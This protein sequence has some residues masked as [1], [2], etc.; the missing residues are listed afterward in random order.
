MKREYKIIL[1]SIAIILAYCIGLWIPIEY[2][3]PTIKEE[4]IG[5]GEYYR[6]IISIIS[7][8]ITFTAVLV[9]LFKDDLR[10]YWKFARINFS[11]PDNHTIEITNDVSNG[12]SDE[13]LQAKK[14]ISRVEIQ[15]TGN[16]PLL[17]SEIYL[18]KLEYFPK[19]ST[20]PQFVECSGS[21]IKWNGSA[22]ETII[23]PPS[24]KKMV[25][26][27][28]IFAPEKIST[29]DSA[30]ENKPAKLIIGNLENKLG[31]NK[32]KW[33]ATYT[34]YAQNHKAKSFVITIEWNGLWK[35]RLT[36]MNNYF[37]IQKK[38]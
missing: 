33:H 27:V 28:E 19:D 34:V 37:K 14:Y 24:G 12:Q 1:I 6:L 36:E 16:L 22:V 25:T 15:N 17:N 7:A 10:E 26:I 5:K 38:A 13:V 11:I 20:I 32:G 23:I 2:L 21:P 35:S 29:P 3:K 31:D 18:E 8:F 30:K 9:A 4:E